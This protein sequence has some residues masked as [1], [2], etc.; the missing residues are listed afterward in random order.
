MSIS[1]CLPFGA[2]ENAFF[3]QPGLY[4]DRLDLLRHTWQTTCI[5]ADGASL[6]HYAQLTSGNLF[7]IYTNVYTSLDC[8]GTPSFTE[9]RIRNLTILRPVQDG[10]FFGQFN[11]VSASQ[12]PH[13]APLV[14]YLNDSAY[15]GLTGWQIDQPK[16]VTGNPCMLGTPLPRG[17]ATY[18][19]FSVS[20]NELHILD[21][22][23]EDPN[24]A[25]APAL[26]EVMYP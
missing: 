23:D 2:S 25:L 8:S 15:C 1:G 18:F 21:T 17:T 10:Y 16:D 26:V 14:Q 13:S 24:F 5:D 7:K 12:T 3:F 11:V 19:Y 9:E 20:E 4:R 6:K 22:D